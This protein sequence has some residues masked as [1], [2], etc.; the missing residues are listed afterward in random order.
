[1]ENYDKF[2]TFV[3]GL[4]IT[5]SKKARAVKV[6]D[7]LDN[8]SFVFTGVRLKSEESVL[9]SRGAKIGSSVSKNTNYLICKDKNAT[10]SKLEKAKNLI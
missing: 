10:S 2:F 1:M 9:L 7:D 4:P 5:I 3:Q 8:M 6:S